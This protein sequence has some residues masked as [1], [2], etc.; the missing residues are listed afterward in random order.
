MIYIMISASTNNW[1]AILDFNRYG[2]GMIEL[3]LIL[4]WLV[5]FTHDKLTEVIKYAQ[6]RTNR[7]DT[8]VSNI[9]QNTPKQY[10]D[11]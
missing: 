7:R 4:L 5:L 3:T 8:Q 9:N 6:T 2:E 11:L 10:Y 1:T